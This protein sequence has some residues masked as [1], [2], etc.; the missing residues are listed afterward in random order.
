ME[1][2]ISLKVKA[3]SPR[4]GTVPFDHV[5]C[6]IDGDY[7]AKIPRA[8]AKATANGIELAI[9]TKCFEY[10]ILLHFEESG[11]PTVDCDGVLRNLRKRNMK[12]YQKGQC[13]FSDIMMHVHVAS[14]RAERLRKPGIRRGDLPEIQNPCSEVYR[15]INAILE[16]P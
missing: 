6:V 3:A 9:S 8:R 4:S 5:W 7:G 1:E 13:N 14:E 12:N 16:S 2:A 11:K 15:L 10:W